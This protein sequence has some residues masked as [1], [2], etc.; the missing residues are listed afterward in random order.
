MQLIKGG[1][2]TRIRTQITI[3]VF[4]TGVTSSGLVALLFLILQ[5]STGTDLRVQMT[6]NRVAPLLRTLDALMPAS[7]TLMVESLRD[8]VV[9]IDF[10]RLAPISESAHGG[11][12]PGL[13]EALTAALG[14]RIRIPV[15]VEDSSGR[16]RLGAQMGDGQEFV[17]R[18]AQPAPLPLIFPILPPLLIFVALSIALSL[19][20]GLR[21]VAPLT[22]FAAAVERFG[23]DGADAPIPEEGPA[24]IRRAT[25]AFNRMRERILRLVGDRT[26]MMMAIS[27]DLRTP[28][29]R[30]RLRTEDIDDAELRSRMRRDMDVMENSIADAVTS[31]RQSSAPEKFERTD[32]A[33]LVGTI[34]DEFTDAGF[35]VEFEAAERVAGWV[36]PLAVSR[37]I[38][39]LV[40]NAT[41]YGTRISVQV[42]Q[43]ASNTARIEVVDDGPGIPAHERQA[44]LKPFYRMDP[45][46][47]DGEGFGLGL[48][49][50]DDVAR[51]HDGQLTLLSSQ[52]NGL[53]ARLDLKIS[54]R[55]LA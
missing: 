8:Q 28:L 23:L 21:I 32:L 11:A 40:Q 44:V 19:W 51:S 17:V 6:I 47:M 4:L 35:S 10:G 31:L 33:S 26:R 53:C 20:A 25:G 9:Q 27:H 43:P 16:L 30:L 14:G 42:S 1:L 37:A 15:A 41:K 18:L 52:P 34:C 54:A 46:R 36:R 45:A 13:S 7:R 29:T 49:I 2:G 38:S 3:L 39:N 5:S 48:A 55:P 50:A 24:E 12:L 22:K